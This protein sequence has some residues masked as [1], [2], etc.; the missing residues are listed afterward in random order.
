MSTRSVTILVVLGLVV[1]LLTQTLYI[2]TEKERA[3]QLRFGEVVVSD[4]PAGLHWKVP[5]IDTVAKFDGRVLTNNSQPERFLTVGRENLIVDAFVKWRVQHPR[6]FY[7]ATAG[8]EFAASER[9]TAIAN[10]ALRAAFGVR[11]IYEVVSGDRDE[12]IREVT[13][14][15][16]EAGRNALGVEV[17]DVRIK[18]ID[19]PDEVSATVFS[20]MESDRE[21]EAREIRSRGEEQAEG[22]RA[23]ADRQRTEIMANAY[24]QAQFIRGEGDADAAQIYAQAFQADRDFYSFW[25]SLQ[26]YNDAFSSDDLFVIEPDNSFFRFMHDANAQP[27]ISLSVQ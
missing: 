3:I 13:E 26:A 16:N 24:R 23:N 9:L 11:T 10:D 25:R 20:R 17:V 8:D 1:L 4:V 15:V 18:R 27:G 2:V 12:L 14:L 6:E 19:L 22:I 21:K 5:F 7:R